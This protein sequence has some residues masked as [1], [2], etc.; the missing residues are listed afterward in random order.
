MLAS[1]T[2]FLSLASFAFAAATKASASADLGAC[3]ML[4][5]DFSHLDHKRFQG[6]NAMTKNCLQFSKNNHTPWE[7]NSCVAAATCWGPENLNSYLQCKDGHYDSASAPKLDTGL[8]AN[9]AGGAKEAL[10]FDKYNSFI[11]ATLSEVG[12]NGLSNESVTLLKDFFWTPFTE[13]GDE[14]YYDDLNVYVHRI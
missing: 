8:Y 14:L 1:A 3:E 11:E 2:T 7:Y 13:D 12:S 4:D 10:T 5:D 9:I 6:C